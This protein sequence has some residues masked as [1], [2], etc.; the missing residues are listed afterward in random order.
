MNC[1]Q[2]RTLSQDGDVFCAECGTELKLDE[3]ALGGVATQDNIDKA[4]GLGALFKY[5]G[6][7][8]LTFLVVYFVVRS[9]IF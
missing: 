2:C 9:W 1:I 6:I 5:I 3:K 8:L 7:F 4:R